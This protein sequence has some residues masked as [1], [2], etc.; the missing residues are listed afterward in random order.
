M[1]KFETWLTGD[2]DTTYIINQRGNQQHVSLRLS[3]NVNWWTI[4]YLNNIY[5][6]SK[7]RK[8]WGQA[9]GKSN[10]TSRIHNFEL[11]LRLNF[12][13]FATKSSITLY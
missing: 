9:F 1:Y 12:V 11:Y 5:N 8:T 13:P 4:L 7:F 2:L 6:Y 10:L 3:S